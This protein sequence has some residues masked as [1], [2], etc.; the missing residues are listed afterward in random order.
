MGIG[1][2]L[3]WRYVALGS[4]VVMQALAQSLAAQG[5]DRISQPKTAAGAVTRAASHAEA[6]RALLRNLIGTWRFEIWFAGN[7][8]GPA[9]VSGTRVVRP[10]FD[11]SR[12]EW[13]EQIDHSAIQGQG[14]MGFDPTTGRFFS[15]AVSSAGPSPE[16][17][18][19]TLD[20]AE[21]TITLSPLSG[22]PAGAAS[23]LT[24][25]DRDH[26]SWVAP[27]RQWRAVFTR[28]DP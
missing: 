13:T 18:S 28:Q 22:A 3:R 7:L 1:N 5:I 14:L 23:S 12:L 4:V 11:D 15:T 21:P 24:V 26:F 20:D 25:L 27:N 6:A 17:L 19:G 9:D 2:G 10:L 16:L 8:T